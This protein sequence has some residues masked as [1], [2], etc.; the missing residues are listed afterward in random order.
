MTSDPFI[1]DGSS[2]LNASL[3]TIVGMGV[4]AA[5]NIYL[6][7]LTYVGRI[8]SVDHRLSVVVD[9]TIS[10]GGRSCLPYQPGMAAKRACLGY[11][12][13]AALDARGNLLLAGM[14]SLKLIQMIVTCVLFQGCSAG[15]RKRSNRNQCCLCSTFGESYCNIYS[16]LPRVTS[17][18]S[19]TFTLGP[20]SI[21]AS[22][23]G[24]AKIHRSIQHNRR[25]IRLFNPS[26]CTVASTTC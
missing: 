8:S 10:F 2:A 24:I 12:T 17:I 15:F 3:Y 21:D 6:V 18:L 22:I 13:S 23:F 20:T 26:C 14:L 19:T 5:G 16:Q 4:D 11:L 9:S 1:H 7:S 25:R